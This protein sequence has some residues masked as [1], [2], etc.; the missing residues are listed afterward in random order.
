[1]LGTSVN[2]HEI[3]IWE[4]AAGVVTL[5]SVFISDGVTKS[6]ETFQTLRIFQVHQPTFFL[7]SFDNFYDEAK[8]YGCGSASTIS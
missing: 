6:H 8:N 3:D 5:K 4:G 2:V 1:M 7:I